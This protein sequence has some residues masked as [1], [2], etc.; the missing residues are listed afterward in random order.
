MKYF[1]T[2]YKKEYDTYEIDA[3]IQIIE[4]SIIKDTVDNKFLLRNIF[5]NCSD[6]DVVALQI[7]ISMYDVFGS[8]VDDSSYQKEFVYQDVI[9]SPDDYFGNKIPIELSDSCR[10]VDIEV[11]KAAFSDGSIWESNKAN[12]VKLEEQQRIQCNNEYF[13]RYRENGFIPNF[14]YLKKDSHW[15]CS[16][17]QPNLLSAETCSICKKQHIDIEKLFS[18][19][20]FQKEY[21]KYLDDL[22]KERERQKKLEEERLRKEEEAKKKKLE[23]ERLKK[24][25]E[26][27]IKK[28]EEENQK[29]IE[30]ERLKKEETILN[31]QNSF[32]RSRKKLYLFCAIIILMLLIGIGTRFTHK[33]GLTNEEKIEIALK[34]REIAVSKWRTYNPS[35]DGILFDIPGNFF[36]TNHDVHRDILVWQTKKLYPNTDY[37]K[38]LSNI[39]E[40]VNE[41]YKDSKLDDGLWYDSKEKCVA[42]TKVLRY[43]AKKIQIAIFWI[44][45]ANEEQALKIY[46]SF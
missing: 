20:N 22:L 28:L 16:C 23:E 21:K 12:I 24:E 40:H 32:K 8:P 17:G 39:K 30:E 11:C 36:L 6:L 19:E 25:Q 31:E 15:Q 3:P 13:N 34:D 10:K 4:T 18:M 29:R 42:F 14:Y 43:D 41:I 37:S 46:N 35:S 26:E 33:N 44:N 9:Y 1:E 38:D 7:K 2:L 45:A 27:K 5:Y